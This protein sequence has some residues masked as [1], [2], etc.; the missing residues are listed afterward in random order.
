[1]ITVSLR[2]KGQSAPCTARSGRGYACFRRGLMKIVFICCLSPADPRSVIQNK[3]Q[4]P[5]ARGTVHPLREAQWKN[6]QPVPGV[7][8]HQLFASNKYTPDPLIKREA[9]HAAHGG[10]TCSR[11]R[12]HL[13]PP[14]V[15]TRHGM[16]SASVFLSCHGF[17]CMICLL[18]K[19]MR[20]D[21]RC[22][23]LVVGVVVVVVLVCI[24]T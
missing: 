23:M 6:S 17:V 20:Y 11:G 22:S 16:S 5:L 7:S 18:L 13:R 8:T 19:S 4:L 1:M 14:R 15:R 9:P 2:G 24:S 21:C 3:R 12:R 10:M